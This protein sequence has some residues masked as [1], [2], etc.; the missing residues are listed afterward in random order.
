MHAVQRVILA[1]MLNIASQRY[2]IFCFH[3]LLAVVHG[4]YLAAIRLLDQSLMRLYVLQMA[5]PNLAK[6]TLA[7]YIT[8]SSAH[9]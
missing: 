2:S 8:P 3:M 4:P 9:S 1:H 5:L 7:Q 6:A